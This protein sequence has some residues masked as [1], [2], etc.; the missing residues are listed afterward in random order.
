MKQPTI[1]NVKTVMRLKSLEPQLFIQQAHQAYHKD[2][3]MSAILA[4]FS[5]IRQ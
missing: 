5:M 3:H 1:W 4:L 2:N